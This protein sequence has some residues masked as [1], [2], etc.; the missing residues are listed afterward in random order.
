D[1]TPDCYGAASDMEMSSIGALRAYLIVKWDDPIDHGSPKS[2]PAEKME[3]VLH[4]NGTGIESIQNSKFKVQNE[5]AAIYDFSGRRLSKPQRGV[6]I[7]EGRKL[8]VK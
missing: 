3:I 2:Q 4:D 6:N 1:T 5:D 7:I 8:M